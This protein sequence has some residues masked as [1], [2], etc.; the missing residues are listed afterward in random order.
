MNKGLKEV[1]L[2]NTAC[3]RVGNGSDN[4]LPAHEHSYK[5]LLALRS[6][7]FSANS[8]DLFIVYEENQTN[9]TWIL[10]LLMFLVFC[11]AF[12]T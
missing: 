8:F 7:V 10:Y 6:M 11:W 1:V 9:S 5:K 3:R 2:P 4:A 12:P